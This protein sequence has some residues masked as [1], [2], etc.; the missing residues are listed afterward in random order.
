ME[1]A[2]LVRMFYHIRPYTAGHMNSS[3]TP[4]PQKHLHFALTT[5]PC[6]ILLDPLK[7]LWQ[8]YFR[9]HPHV[10]ACLTFICYWIATK[11]MHSFIHVH[12]IRVYV[13]L[14]HPT[15]GVCPPSWCTMID[16]LSTGLSAAGSLR[17]GKSLYSVW[18]PK[19][20]STANKNT[21]QGAQIA[22]CAA[23]A[24]VVLT[25]SHDETQEKQ[26]RIKPMTQS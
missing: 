24:I 6:Q 1:Y 11:E 9:S 18:L 25:V 23:T 15:H 7:Q 26:W 2:S 20:A 13:T 22:T 8:T 14:S 4:H 21:A 19:T 12:I 5:Y 16:E 3:S 17:G 10:H